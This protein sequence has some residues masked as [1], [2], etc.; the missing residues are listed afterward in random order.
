MALGR[1]R[2]QSLCATTHEDETRPKLIVHLGR[3]HNSNHCL[4]LSTLLHH[5]QIP[6]HPKPEPQVRPDEVLEAE[7]ADLEPNR[8]HKGQIQLAIAGGQL[9]AYFTPPQRQ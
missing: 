9:R 2:W 3:R 7:M 8:L 1:P 6:P 5:P 4:N